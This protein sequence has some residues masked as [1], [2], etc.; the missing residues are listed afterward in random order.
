MG[1]IV[2]NFFISLDGVVEAPDQWHFPYFNDEMGNAIGGG[3]Q[4]TEAFFMGRVL[5]EEWAEYWPQHADDDFGPFINN[6]PKYVV[7]NTLT[8]ATWDNTTLV[9][10]DVKA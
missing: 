9:T 5:Y 10:G 7:S 1:R 6:I 8:E 4:S 3:M 2:S